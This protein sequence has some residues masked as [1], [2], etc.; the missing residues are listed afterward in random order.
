[1]AF[2]PPK[3]RSNK[4]AHI[5]NI[6]HKLQIIIH[7]SSISELVQ[8]IPLTHKRKEGRR[9]AKLQNAL[10]Q[11]RVTE[12]KTASLEPSSSVCPLFLNPYYTEG[13]ESPNVET[14]QDEKDSVE[15]I[16]RLLLQACRVLHTGPEPEPLDNGGDII[17]DWT[18]R[19]FTSNAFHKLIHILVNHDTLSR[20]AE[21]ISYDLIPDEAD[22]MT[23]SI[24]KK[25]SF[26]SRFTRVLA[27]EIDDAVHEAALTNGLGLWSGLHPQRRASVLVGNKLGMR[28]PCRC[29][30]GQEFDRVQWFVL[31]IGMAEKSKVLPEIA[32]SYI[33]RGTLCVMTVNIQRGFDFTVAYTL[34]RRGEKTS[35]LVD[36]VARYEVVESSQ[37]DLLSSLTLWDFFPAAVLKEHGITDLGD[38]RVR[39]GLS[40]KVIWKCFQEAWNSET[41]VSQELRSFQVWRNTNRG[42]THLHFRPLN[43]LPRKSTTI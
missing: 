18:S 40:G 39:L 32:R 29:S 5:L 31:E 26:Q 34:Y 10:D 41:S 20:S 24:R 2:S 8:K 17:W 43:S 38:Q 23:I 1:M 22:C 35:E 37:G 7:R 33:E 30:Q 36:G 21:N 11:K 19:R 6:R 16:A 3:T 12:N 15:Q 9:M 25:C 42:G 13:A 28:T 27:S 14:N 4:S